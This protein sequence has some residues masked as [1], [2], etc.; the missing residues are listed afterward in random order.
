[1]SPAILCTANVKDETTLDLRKCG[2][3]LSSKGALCENRMEHCVQRTGFCENGNCEGTNKKSYR[4][5]PMPTCK[6]WKTCNCSCH[7]SYD[8]MF[9]MSEMERT[10]VDNSGY[11][12]DRGGFIMPTMEERMAALVLSRPVEAPR[13]RYE[14]SPAPDLVPAS[15]VRS[16]APTATGRAASGELESWVKK[17][18]DIWLVESQENEVYYT[19]TPS[20]L[21][22]QIADNEGIKAPS[23]GAISAVFDR[24]VKIG[25]ADCQKKPTRFVKYTEQGIKL[26]LIGCKERF[27][28]N[29]KTAE[30]E[31]GRSFRR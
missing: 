7:L 14:E 29:K 27:K 10:V 26:G 22:E 15:V 16:Y 5:T 8:A 12:P 17:H 20:Y 23:V 6:L 19:C 11:S 21:S 30:A 31:A 25:F 4:G 9:K 13:T 3:I 24:W 1:M 2:T 28:R 18:C